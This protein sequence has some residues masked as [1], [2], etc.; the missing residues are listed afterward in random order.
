VA[1]AALLGRTMA[2]LLVCWSYA[3]KRCCETAANP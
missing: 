2:L 1:V 3:A